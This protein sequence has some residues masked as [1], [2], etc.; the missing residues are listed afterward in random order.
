MKIPGDMK[1]S[2][3][4]C[5]RH[6]T[7]H[8]THTQK[9]G[10]SV[11]RSQY[12]ASLKPLLIANSICSQP[13]I[14]CIQISFGLVATKQ[15]ISCAFLASVVDHYKQSDIMGFRAFER[16]AL[17][18]FKDLPLYVHTTENCTI[19]KKRLKTQLFAECYDMDDMSISRSYSV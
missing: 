6:T 10:T 16:C 4:C 8:T 18:L 14:C 7:T 17:R 12:M 19:L 9:H 5:D 11:S 13:S 15:R 3:P 1:R 2:P